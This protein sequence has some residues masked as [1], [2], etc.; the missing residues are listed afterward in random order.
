MLHQDNHPRLRENPP[1]VPKHLFL[2]KRQEHESPEPDTPSIHYLDKGNS[3]GS[4]ITHNAYIVNG[5][6][7]GTHAYHDSVAS[8]VT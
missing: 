7:S 3:M 2:H 5:A 4:A 8:K 6:F 1:Q